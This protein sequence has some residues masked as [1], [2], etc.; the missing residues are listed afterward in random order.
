MMA[1]GDTHVELLEALSPDSA[2][3][4]FITKR[5]PGIHHIAIE[6]KDIR[7]SLTELKNKGARLIDENPRLG[8][9]GCLVAFVHPSTTNGVLLEL[10]Q[11]Q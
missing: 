7:Q 9:G 6:V 11:H 2:V 4:K 10:V 1:V 5:G 8:A 3:G